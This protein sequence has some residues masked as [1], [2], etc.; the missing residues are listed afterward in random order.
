VSENDNQTAGTP[1]W[2]KVFGIVTLV[3]V[4]VVV[5][6]L[7]AGRG[8]HGPGRHAPGGDGSGTHTGPPTGVTHP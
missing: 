1:R 7:I 4:V 6:M 5:V 2:V 8:G 3:L